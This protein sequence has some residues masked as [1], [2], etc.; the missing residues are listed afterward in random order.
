MN[1][2]AKARSIALPPPWLKPW[3]IMIRNAN[4]RLRVAVDEQASASSHAMNR[5]LCLRTNGHRVRRLPTGAL[6][7]AGGVVSD[8]GDSV[9]AVLSVIASGA[10]RA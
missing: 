2:N 10:S 6:A 5:P 8:S 3:S 1:N 9:I 7:L 4:G